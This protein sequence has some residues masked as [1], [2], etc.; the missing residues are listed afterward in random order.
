VKI[1]WHQEMISKEFV[2][3]ETKKKGKKSV[4]FDAKSSKEK[5]TFMWKTLSPKCSE[6][7]PRHWLP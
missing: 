3:E 4:H 7:L 1:D 2:E 6:R 5:K